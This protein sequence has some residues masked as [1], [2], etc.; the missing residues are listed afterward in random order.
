MP[1]F[2]RACRKRP[3]VAKS[4]TPGFAT[5]AWVA[6]GRSGSSASSFG[7]SSPV[8]CR[9]LGPFRPTCSRRV[10]RSAVD[11]GHIRSGPSAAHA[12][13]AIVA[14]LPV[15]SGKGLRRECASAGRR[16]SATDQNGP[17]TGSQALP[18]ATRGRE[19]SN[20][21]GPLVASVTARRP[22]DTTQ[23]SRPKHSRR[24]SA[25]ELARSQAARAPQANKPRSGRPWQLSRQEH[26][27]RSSRPRP[28][29]GAIAASQGCMPSWA[30]LPRRHSTRPGARKGRPSQARSS[31]HLPQAR[32]LRQEV[33]V[34]CRLNAEGVR[35]LTS[36][37]ESAT[38]RQMSARHGR[39]QAALTVCALRPTFSR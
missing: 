37:A 2:T 36:S 17:T 26:P 1:Q 12:T 8:S 7:A 31:R 18:I 39:G 23:D 35:R 14:D 29:S 9:T 4:R 10:S 20:H 21:Q 11:R 22:R 15:V 30:Q 25:N 3:S 32:R 16:R 27:T 5:C 13:G 6:A 34:P 28:R 19:P 24:K 38:D 33:P